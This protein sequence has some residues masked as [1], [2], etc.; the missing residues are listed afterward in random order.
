VL[1]EEELAEL[2]GLG[3]GGEREEEAEEEQEDGGTHGRGYE[4]GKAGR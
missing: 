4:V 2:A 1:P 3:A